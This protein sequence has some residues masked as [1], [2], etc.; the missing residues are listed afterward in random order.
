MSVGYGKELQAAPKDRK[1]SIERRRMA[2]SV[3]N[4]VPERFNSPRQRGR[5][6]AQR[7]L[8]QAIKTDLV[9]HLQDI[10]ILPSIRYTKS[11]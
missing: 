10:G 1:P 8:A 2:P 11:I 5:N 9:N 3:A 4:Y 7:S 6:K